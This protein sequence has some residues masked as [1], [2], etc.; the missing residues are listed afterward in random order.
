VKNAEV[1]PRARILAADAV[2]VETWLD[3][4][5][6]APSLDVLFSATN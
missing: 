3:R 6:D 4:L 5:M 2:S 1:G